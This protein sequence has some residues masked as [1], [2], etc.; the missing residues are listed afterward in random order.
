MKICLNFTHPQY[1]QNVDEFGSSSDP[2][3]ISFTHQWILCSEW[4]P[5]EWAQTADRNITIIH[6][7][8]VHQLTSWE[9]KSCMFVTNKSIINLLMLL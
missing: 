5:S 4:V 8:S 7:S 6:T 9:A 3:L 2:I 1:N